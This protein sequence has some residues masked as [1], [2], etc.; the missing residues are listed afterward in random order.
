MG[1]FPVCNKWRNCESEPRLA[2]RDFYKMLAY[3]LLPA[4][5]M[6]VLREYLCLAAF[7]YFGK[8][9][10][11]ESCNQVA[12]SLGGGGAH[13]KVTLSFPPFYAGFVLHSA[14]SNVSTQ[15]SS[16]DHFKSFSVRMEV[17][18]YVPTRLQIH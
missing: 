14:T 7:K 17:A 6:H 2:S 10:L 3:K 9:V 11:M 15:K 18:S 16:S 1:Q 8:D 4:R 5:D 12:R 13:F